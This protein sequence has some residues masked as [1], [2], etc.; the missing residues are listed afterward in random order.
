MQL[1][2][3][4][5]LAFVVDRVKPA[6]LK[7]WVSRDGGKS[8]PEKDAFV[9]YNHEEKAAVTQGQKNVDYAQYWEDMGKWSF[10][11]PVI[12][13]LADGKVLLLYYAGAPERMSIH[14]VRV[15]V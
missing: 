12:H 14:W 7:L 13:P 5:V 1:A 10:G 2:D 3:G 9:V 6:T 11:H 4:R 8:W 15:A